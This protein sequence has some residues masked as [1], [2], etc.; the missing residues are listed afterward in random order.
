MTC[1]LVAVFAFLTVLLWGRG[2]IIGAGSVV[3]KSIP[4]Y[5]IACGV[6]AGVIK[7][8]T[9]IATESAPK[10]NDNVEMDF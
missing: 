9:P 8:R 10:Q 3:N 2:C 6:P 7:F 4:D 5:A 1:G